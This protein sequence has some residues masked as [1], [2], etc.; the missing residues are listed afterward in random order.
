MNTQNRKVGNYLSACTLSVALFGCS[1][2]QQSHVTQSAAGQGAGPIPATSSEAG[3]IPASSEGKA[4]IDACV[5]VY[6]DALCKRYHLN[7]K[8]T[9]AEE[10]KHYLTSDTF[11]KDL[12]NREWGGSITVP[13]KGVPVTLAAC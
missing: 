9:F 2:G 6:K 7:T 11:R 5:T 3:G 10:F 1:S 4:C 13:I 8:A 12:Q